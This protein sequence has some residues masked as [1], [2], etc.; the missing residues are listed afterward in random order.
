MQQ[1]LSHS[2]CFP[3]DHSE[4]TGKMKGREIPSAARL[5]QYLVKHLCMQVLALLGVG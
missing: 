3:G 5:K 4:E 2:S 1:V